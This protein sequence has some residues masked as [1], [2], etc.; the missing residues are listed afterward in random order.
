MAYKLKNIFNTKSSLDSNIF[1]SKNLVQY[2]Y[3]KNFILKKSFE[4]SRFIYRLDFYNYFFNLK[5][6]RSKKLGA[7][8]LFNIGYYKNEQNFKIKY[9]LKNLSS[10]FSNYHI[11][12]KYIL[13]KLKK[14]HKFQ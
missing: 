12:K 8:F 14:K 10:V 3:P 13:S 2:K 9:R 4:D 7:T 6:S 1:I 5:H 11:K